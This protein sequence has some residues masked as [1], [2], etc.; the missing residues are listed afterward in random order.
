MRPSL[1]VGQ[2]V[3]LDSLLLSH[4]IEVIGRRHHHARKRAASSMHPSFAVENVQDR[5]LLQSD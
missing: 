3:A 1:Y 2:S 4:A 5:N